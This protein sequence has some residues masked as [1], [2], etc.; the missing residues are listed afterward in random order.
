MI[1]VKNQNTSQKISFIAVILLFSMFIIFG[2]LVNTDGTNFYKLY[3]F[4]YGIFLLIIILSLS[5]KNKYN[6]Y[7][8][9]IW[10]AWFYIGNFNIYFSYKTYFIYNYHYIF[11]YN[12]DPRK[13]NS[14]YLLYFLFFII[15]MKVFEKV[16]D[17]SPNENTNNLLY[18]DYSK[19][20]KFILFIF[21]FMLLGEIY[22]LHG[23]IPLFSGS[24]LS[25]T[26]YETNHG[27]LYDYFILISVM[28]GIY[29]FNNILDKKNILLNMFTLILNI[30][31]L[32]AYGMRYF[33]AILVICLLVLLIKRFQGKQLKIILLLIIFF[34]FVF[35]LVTVLMRSGT[36]LS[37]E[38]LYKAIINIGPEYRDW[39]YFI[40]FEPLFKYNVLKES[41]PYFIPKFILNI[42][43]I[44]R[45]NTS[46]S[47]MA[48]YFNVDFG[49]RIGLIGEL[50]WSY[51]YYGIIVFFII[52]F[53]SAFFNKK[54]NKVNNIRDFSLAAIWFSVSILSIM[55]QFNVVLT[56]IKSFI[57]IYI[58]FLF[59]KKI[60]LL[61]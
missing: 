36:E 19:Y 5:F 32:L 17:N 61:I 52:G 26:M 6:K 8:S 51:R 38:S 15:A 57:Y 16:F 23:Q 37:K 59:F 25:M 12:I 13:A 56:T 46:A 10:I 31:V 11:D 20:E 28:T 30:T 48:N 2:L 43:K 9:L 3:T 47:Y 1:N 49:I 42:F 7:F 34:M 27:I 54:L 22:Y 53:I 4:D 40:Q 39:A 45:G 55:G 44:T 50:Y 33:F 21:S 41:L 24:N 35:Y 58:I 14:V 29:N 18:V 60:N